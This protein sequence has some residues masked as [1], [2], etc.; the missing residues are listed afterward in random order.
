[1]ILNQHTFKL[2][3]SYNDTSK[4]G[5]GGC[6]LLIT[7]YNKNYD[8]KNNNN[9]I[10]YEYTILSRIWD[11]IEY[12]SQI[13]NIP[14]NEYI[15]G[16]FDKGSIT[17]HYYSIFIPNGTERIIIQFEGNYLDGFIAEGIVKINTIKELDGIFKLDII[18][19]QHFF[20]LKKDDFNNK[21]IS[22]AFRSKNYFE[23]I[24]SFYYFR[25]FYLK[26]NETLFYPVDSNLGNLCLPEKNNETDKYYCDLILNNNYN[27]LSSNFAIAG[28]NQIEYFKI[29]YAPI[30]KNGNNEEIK[31]DSK[32]FKYIFSDITESN[33][34]SHIFFRFEFSEGGIKNIVS[35]FADKSSD[36][37]PQIYSGQ[38]YLLY[39]IVPPNFILKNNI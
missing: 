3:F 11:Y 35:A 4:C 28:T 27:E 13:V 7:Y 32:E 6:Y 26:A 20:N 19:N 23:D 34:I 38:M 12:S 37:C 33:K 5:N 31:Y 25:I 22:L 30:Y 15:L 8:K 16:T 29:F 1:M 21:Y 24:F 10:G 2:Y 9:I 39:D 17:H 36:N 14:F 18:N